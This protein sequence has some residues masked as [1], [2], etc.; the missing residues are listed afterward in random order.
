MELNHRGA[1]DV[2]KG[3]DHLGRPLHWRGYG[4]DTRPIAVARRRASG[5]ALGMLKDRIARPAPPASMGP[6]AKKVLGELLKAQRASVVDLTAFRRGRLNAEELQ[7]SAV[8]AERLAGSHPVHALF[9]YVQN[10]VSIM[11]ETVAALPGLDKH[12]EIIGKAEAEYMPRGPPM[13]PLTMSHF[14]MWAY[15]DATVGPK[16]ETIGTVLL[17]LYGRLGV[18]PAFIRVVRAMQDSRL[19]L[20]RRERQQTDGLFVLR[21][22]VTEE[23]SSC[24]VPSGWIGRDGELWLGRIVR[25]AQDMPPLFVTTPYVIIEPGVDQWLACFKRTLVDVTPS[26]YAEHMKRPRERHHWNEY[27]FEAYMNH[28]TEAIFLRGLPDVP[29]S[30]PH[31]KVN[32]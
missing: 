18:H 27:I 13:S 7:K 16:R 5:Y 6:I 1:L 12:L 21:E 25:V 32:S 8:T 11:S 10:Q 19:G 15:F 14:S 29:E 17:A 2:A 30:R 31:S 3:D 24:V 23:S 4:K 26:K 22:L 28:V 20:Y 9:I